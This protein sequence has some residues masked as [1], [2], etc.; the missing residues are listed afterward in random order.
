MTA[1]EQKSKIFKAL[2]DPSRLRIL[3][4][5]SCGELCACRILESFGFTQPTLSH[6]MKILMACGLV[7][8]RKEGLWC[9][10][11]LNE[12]NVKDLV[13]S[14]THLTQEKADC[15]FHSKEDNK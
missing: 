6:H 9:H 10:Y 14:L 8:S 3:D 2:G 13:Q 5:L 15:I 11:S 7:S 12:E 4:M 1:Y